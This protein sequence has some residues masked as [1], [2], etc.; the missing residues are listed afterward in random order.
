MKVRLGLGETQTL[1]YWQSLDRSRAMGQVIIF[2]PL[3]GGE[4]GG[5]DADCTLSHSPKIRHVWDS[6]NVILAIVRRRKEAYS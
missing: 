5:E 2:C 4:E 3:K 1:M 6:W